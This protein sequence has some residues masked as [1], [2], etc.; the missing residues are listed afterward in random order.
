MYSY[1][2]DSST[3]SIEEFGYSSSRIIEQ[4]E[5]KVISSPLSQMHEKQALK[6]YYT[7][8]HAQGHFIISA[9]TFHILK[10]FCVLIQ[11]RGALCSKH[12]HPISLS[13]RYTFHSS[14]SQKL[15]SST[16]K[17]NCGLTCTFTSFFLLFFWLIRR[18]YQFELYRVARNKIIQ[19]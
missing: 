11:K 9:N 15:A 14:C 19:S 7:I 16:E 8:C 18:E 10:S 1:K 12:F 3:L 13:H 4:L 17:S 2:A 6:R 5:S